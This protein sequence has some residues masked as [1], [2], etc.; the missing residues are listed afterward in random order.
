MKIKAL[1]LLAV[2]SLVAFVQVTNAQGILRGDSQVS[3][4]QV[5]TKNL[6]QQFEMD[7]LVEEMVD[8][9]YELDVDEGF[10]EEWEEEFW[11]AGQ[12]DEI[13][14]LIIDPDD[15]A[16]QM[17][18]ELVS[19]D[20]EDGW[21]EVIDTDIFALV[22]DENEEEGLFRGD[23]MEYEDEG[24]LWIDSEEDMEIDELMLGSDWEDQGEELVDPGWEEVLE[25]WEFE[26]MEF[27]MEDDDLDFL[28]AMYNAF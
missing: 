7:L 10:D 2:L 15:N 11:I 5:T 20:L 24:I 3:D 1:F 17:D 25:Q 21:E 12:E 13:D 22:E 9:G 23:G 18:D 6:Q 19:E 8:A 4:S 14:A 27:E 16:V 28:E 26:D